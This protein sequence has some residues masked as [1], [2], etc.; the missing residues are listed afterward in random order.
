MRTPRGSPTCQRRRQTR[1]TERDPD[2]SEY[3]GDNA[4]ARCPVPPDIRATAPMSPTCLRARQAAAV[5]RRS[6][7]AFGRWYPSMS[8]AGRRRGDRPRRAPDQEG[9]RAVLGGSRGMAPVADGLEEIIVVEEAPVPR[10]VLARRAVR[11]R[12]P[13]AGHRQIRTSTAANSCRSSVSSARTSRAAPSAADSARAVRHRH[14]VCRSRPGGRSTRCSTVSMPT[15]CERRSSSPRRSMSCVPTKTSSSTTSGDTCRGLTTSR[16]WSASRSR[17]LT[18]STNSPPTDLHGPCP[19]SRR[20]SSRRLESRAPIELAEAAGYDGIT[21]SGSV[22]QRGGQGAKPGVTQ[23][24][25]TVASRPRRSA[26]RS[27]A[28]TLAP[29]DAPANRPSSRAMP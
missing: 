14:V 21:A 26:T 20:R 4:P 12:A 22:V 13:A 1:R 28:T 8:A 17:G 6:V 27:A 10:A 11:H 25:W 16:R 5:V 9:Q 3:R 24:R 15:R 23:D 7:A 2:P 19:R 29:E 18:R